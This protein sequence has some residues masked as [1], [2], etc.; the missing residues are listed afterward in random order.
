MWLERV[1]ITPLV[2]CLRLAFHDDFEE[3][4]LVECFHRLDRAND[5]LPTLNRLA[6]PNPQIVRIK[7]T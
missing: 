1:E 6:E 5:D 4:V 2:A 3:L 7:A